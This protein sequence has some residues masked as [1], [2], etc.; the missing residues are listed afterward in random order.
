VST[1]D[2][3][4]ARRARVAR[5]VSLGK[6]IG[7]GCFGGALVL[8]F[9]GLIGRFSRFV[10]SVTVALLLIGCL[11]LPPA[12]VFGYGLRAAEREEREVRAARD[13]RRS[14]QGRDG[15]RNIADGPGGGG[16]GRG[17]R[18]PAEG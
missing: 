12:I 3:V 2:P 5:L 11:V 7:Y 8:F 4:D 18:P 15:G 9:V 6:G 1:P 16:D 10:S 14:H 13:L 17:S